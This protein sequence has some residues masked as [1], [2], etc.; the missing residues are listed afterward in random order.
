LSERAAPISRYQRDA[1]VEPIN[2]WNF[3]HNWCY[4]V[5]ALANSGRYADAVREATALGALRLEDA[6]AP[7]P[8]PFAVNASRCFGRWVF[9]G[10]LALPMVHW[11]FARFD[12]CAVRHCAAMPRLREIEALHAWNEHVV[13][14][15]QFLQPIAT[16][17]ITRACVACRRCRRGARQ[18]DARA[19]APRRRRE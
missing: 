2:N 12:R 19:R 14:Y 3:V 16:E 11:R 18:R 6:A 8:L 1:N 5:H 13:Q 7:E 17:W 9:Q 4:L 15:F 10:L